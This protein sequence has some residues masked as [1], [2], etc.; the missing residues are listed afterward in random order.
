LPPLL[1][2]LLRLE[3][4]V[5]AVERLEVPPPVELQPARQLYRQLLL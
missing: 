4:G 3:E 5:G 2:R 1:N